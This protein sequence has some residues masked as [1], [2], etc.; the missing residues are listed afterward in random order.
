MQG[1]LIMVREN[2]ANFQEI[3][4]AF[5]ITHRM[6]GNSVFCTLLLE[7]LPSVQRKIEFA[8]MASEIQK[9]MQDF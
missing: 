5:E 6:S 1:T 3:K 8:A 7:V 9:V 2:K 4:K